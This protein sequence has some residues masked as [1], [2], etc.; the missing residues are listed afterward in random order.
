MQFY[1]KKVA[2]T[3]LVELDIFARAWR[4][5]ETITKVAGGPGR[6]AFDK[7]ALFDRRGVDGV[8]NGVG[9]LVQTGGHWLRQFQTGKVRSYA[10]G[11]AVGAVILLAYF[12]ARASF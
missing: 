6:R 9:S 12:I 7:I 8:V 5:D 2:P 1:L 3:R 10:L 11:I 4:Y